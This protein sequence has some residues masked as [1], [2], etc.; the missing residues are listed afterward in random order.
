MLWGWKQRFGCMRFW[1][2]RN[3]TS[4]AGRP[5]M[6]GDFMPSLGS[7]VCWT[8][9]TAIPQKKNDTTMIQKINVFDAREAYPLSQR[10]DIRGGMLHEKKMILPF[11]DSYH[12][13]PLRSWMLSKKKPGC[14]NLSGRRRDH[15]GS[16]G[17]S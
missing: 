16:G 15:T 13:R 2:K 14:V 1:G 3:L 6:T 12:S 11:F 8:G 10:R 4:K 7:A 5:L 9:Q 17:G